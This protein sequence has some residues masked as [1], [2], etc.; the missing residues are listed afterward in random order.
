MIPAQKSNKRRWVKNRPSIVKWSAPTRGISS[1]SHAM[2]D[3][4]GASWWGMDPTHAAFYGRQWEHDGLDFSLIVALPKPWCDV[5]TAILSSV[6][7]NSS[8]KRNPKTNCNEFAMIE[9]NSLKKNP[10]KVWS[11]FSSLFIYQ[12]DGEFTVDFWQ[13]F[14]HFTAWQTCLHVSFL[15]CMPAGKRSWALVESI[16]PLSMIKSSPDYLWSFLLCQSWT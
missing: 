13:Y 16:S 14:L 9:Y 15:C 7:G 6:S 10:L 12:M 8:R 5:E 2:W 1:L 4:R 3:Q 11:G